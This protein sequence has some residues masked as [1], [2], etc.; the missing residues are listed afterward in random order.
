MMLPA[1]AAQCQ[2]PATVL[3]SGYR[4]RLQCTEAEAQLQCTDFPKEQ[5]S[6]SNLL[7]QMQKKEDIVC[8]C[9]CVSALLL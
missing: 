2:I 5:H 4:F 3:D 8:R 1:E 9:H 7:C 6:Y